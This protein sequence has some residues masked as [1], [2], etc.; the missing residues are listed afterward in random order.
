MADVRI[1]D[2]ST[3]STLNGSDLFIAEQSSAGTGAVTYTTLKNTLLGTSGIT[4]LGGTDVCSA[5][6][7]LNTLS[8]YGSAARHNSIGRGSSLGTS[9]T[10]TQWTQIKSGTF[11]GLYIGDYWTIGGVNYRIAAFDYYLSKKSL[12]T[13]HVVIVP[14]TNL[15]SNVAMNTTRDATG[16]YYGTS[17]YTTT[18]D[19][20]RTTVQNAFGSAHI[21]SHDIDIS[22]AASGGVVTGW[23]SATVDIALMT[24]A[25][26]YGLTTSVPSASQFIDEDRQQFPLFFLFP[27]LQTINALYWLRDVMTD[28][29]FVSMGSSAASR[30]Y[31]DSA[32]CGIRPSFC[33]YQA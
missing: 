1:S 32:T 4:R 27:E 21:L 20:A 23:Q 16:G 24:L 22:N 2:L 9:V 18:I 19:A 13:H 26:L 3:I 6:N 15:V 17:M 12:S 7:R 31:A 28:S 25:N 11:Q 30:R 10:S 5:I 33:I 29:A 14:D 8:D